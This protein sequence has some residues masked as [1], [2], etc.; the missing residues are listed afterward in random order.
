MTLDI[1]TDGTVT[2]D[3]AIAQAAQ[4]LAEHFSLW[5]VATETPAK[6]KKKTKKE[7]AAEEEI[8]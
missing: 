2:V 6:A 4:I 8:E 1:T 7:I 5:N 3:E